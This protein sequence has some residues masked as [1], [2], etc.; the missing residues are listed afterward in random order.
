ML[1]CA[2]V[3]FQLLTLAVING[4]SAVALRRPIVLNMSFQRALIPLATVCTE[5][6]AFAASLLL[7]ALLMAVY[8]IGPTLALLWLPLVLAITLLLAVALSYAAALFGLY[9]PDL[10]TLGI[11]LMRT[12]FFLSPG[13]I[14][15]S[16]IPD[17]AADIVRLNPLSGIFEAWRQVL[18]AGESPEAWMLLIPLAAAA[19]ILALVA[20]LWRRDQPHFAKVLG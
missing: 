9:W 16:E 14:A 4:M 8:G 5:S 11:S 15:L 18:I 13:L 1:A 20:P 17:D 6:V 19:L 3:P 7:P 2:V 12:L 10:R